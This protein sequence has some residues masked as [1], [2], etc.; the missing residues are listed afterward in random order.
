MTDDN[1][2]TEVAEIVLM[3]Q[4][5]A[6]LAEAATAA[7][8]DQSVSIQTAEAL[9][10]GDPAVQDSAPEVLIVDVD[11]NR[12]ESLA[13]IARL[14]AR[15][16]DRMAVIVV[17][18]HLDEHLTRECLRM[19]VSDILMKPV[20]AVELAAT[21]R[22]SISGDEAT[23]AR[24]AQIVTFLPAAGGVG[25][26]TL[27]LQAAFLLHREKRRGAP[28][29]C[30]AD[31]NFQNGACADFLD[32]EPRLDLNEVEPRPERLDRQ[33]LEVMISR[34]DSG[35]SV[36][37]APNRPAEMRSFDPAMVT[38]LLDL[39]SDN[40]D[41]V[42]IDMPRTWFSWTDSV[43]LGSDKLYIVSEATIPG[44]RQT[45]RLIKAIDDRFAGDVTPQVIVNRY[46][47]RRFGA[48]L[49][50]SDIES[51]LSDRFLG[52]VGNNYRLVREAVDRGVPIDEIEPNNTITTDLKKMLFPEQ[53]K[54]REGSSLGWLMPF[55]KR[56]S[57]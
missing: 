50:L 28:A 44:L 56:A 4:D 54:R 45:Q 57:G 29:T 23:P 31:L 9:L 42:V 46:D 6:L 24:D 47:G 19:R 5:A 2:Q 32:L 3:T 11:L 13:A 8:A 20:S 17:T 55:R 35:V 51:V 34:H 53:E 22:R 40:F 52:T 49:Q 7:E 33:L 21:W 36:L 41:T 48:G 15:T 39:V 30:I 10:S 38:R 25:V 18:S 14:V 27:A 37:A 43:L 12:E 26:T 16:R 1:A